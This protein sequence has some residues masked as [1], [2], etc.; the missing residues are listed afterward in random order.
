MK[1]YVLII[2][3]TLHLMN[4]HL[5]LSQKQG[6]EKID[7]LLIELARSKEDTNKVNIL[8]LL[9]SSYFLINPDSGHT[10]ANNAY[11][12][13]IR[14]KW[15]KGIANSLTNIGISYWLKSDYPKALDYLFK[16]LKIYEEIGNKWGISKNLGN[17]GM[18]YYNQNDYS[19]AIDYY[20]RA[21]KLSI[22][23]DDH[24][25]IAKNNNNIG[26]IY[27]NQSESN[28]ALEYFNKS[29]T[30]FQKLNDKNGIANNLGNIGFIYYYQSD[31]PK[32]LDYSFKSLKIFKDM[33]NIRGILINLGSLSEIYNKLT[34]DSIFNKF[35]GKSKYIGSTKDENLQLEMKYL[36][37]RK[38]VV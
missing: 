36:L 2:I 4:C 28:K 10:F 14:L 11:K 27:L 33:G 31:Y 1:K 38:S 7:S 34:E 25:G 12:I 20:S 30:Y 18:V 9:S 37:D 26:L 15:S 23:L 3:F 6:K 21:L 16:S 13:A 29:L 8:N 19:K 22:E 35:K 24:S 32:A 5:L 17:I